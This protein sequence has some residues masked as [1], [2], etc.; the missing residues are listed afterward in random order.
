MAVREVDDALAK[1]FSA[2]WSAPS[3]Q[4]HG[5][6]PHFAVEPQPGAEHEASSWAWPDLVDVL[7]AQHGQQFRSMAARIWEISAQRGVKV[8][9]FTSAHRAEGRTTF[10][11]LVAKFL[12]AGDRRVVLLDADFQAPMVGARLSLQR[13]VGLYDLVA[14]AGGRVDATRFAALDRL[15]VVPLHEPIA[16]PREIL[17]SGGWSCLMATLRRSFDLVV[18]DG[19][20]VLAGSSSVM[21][22][23]SVDACLLVTRPGDAAERARCQAQEIL[24]A[25]GTPVLGLAENF[26]ALG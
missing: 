3:K 15:R 2:R 22:S 21:L 26:V 19:G 7:E 4:S 9:L 12:A 18:L 8:L 17:S 20:P 24:A 5:Q 6:G 1:A 25:A 13:A 11:L 14:S 23:K 16:R 10:A